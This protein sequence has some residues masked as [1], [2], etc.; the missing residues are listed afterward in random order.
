MP[1][2]VL[3]RI[4]DN[5]P[6]NATVVAAF[7][8]GPDSVYLITQ[9]LQ[10]RKKKQFEIILAHFN[11]QLRGKESNDDALFCKQFAKTH[12]LK[13]EMETKDIGSLQGNTEDNARHHRY[14][15][16]RTVKQR[17]QA[18]RIVTGHHL[19]DNIE[20]FLMHFLRGS[21]IKGLQGMQ[22]LSSDLFRPLLDVPKKEIL[23]YLEQNDMSFCVDKTNK[24]TTY[25]RNN[26]RHTII[27]RLR[28]IQ[29][30]LDD[31]FIRQWHILSENQSY[32]ETMA[33]NVIRKYREEK[34]GMPLDTFKDQH[35]FLQ[36]VI[37]HEL[38]SSYHNKYNE[39]NPV[40]YATLQRAQRA[41]NEAKTG[42]S[43]PFGPKTLLSVDARQ[44]YIHPQKKKQKPFPK[45]TLSIPGETTYA[46]GRI[47][48]SI[49]NHA[50]SDMSRD[51]YLDY[52]TCTFP[53]Y[54]RSRKKGDTFT[55]IGMKGSQKLQDFFVNNKI[56]SKKRN[57]IP[58]IVDKNDTI[59][60]IGTHAISNHH[61]VS[62]ATEKI[63][64]LCITPSLENNVK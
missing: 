53:L 62:D 21:G 12:H 17:H 61:K 28:S 64:K 34:G 29:P 48:A 16:L 7:S 27:P 44:L 59:L 25:T 31:I 49:E 60:A 46:H 13:I 20:T 41:I 18:W 30:S 57:N 1:A 23:A 15:F 39:N 33:H 5:V 9:L 45:T 47:N 55:N 4:T 24:D 19:D 38:Y 43:V 22:T 50:P 51:I 58:L 35:P 32:V 42:T 54:V 36:H 40:S 3:Q 10:A 56:S 11:H 37:L 26:I 8:G 14:T 2:H 52:H 6:E 63:I